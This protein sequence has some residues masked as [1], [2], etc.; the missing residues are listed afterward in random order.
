M[1]IPKYVP[2]FSSFLTLVF[3]SC[4]EN[5]ATTQLPDKLVDLH[6]VR[7]ES[8]EVAQDKLT[9]MHHGVDFAE[10]ESVIGT[11]RDGENEATVYLTIFDGREDH[12]RGEWGWPGSLF[13]P[14][15][16]KQCLD[17]RTANAVRCCLS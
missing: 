11:Y 13:F 6:L 16:Q 12:S 9:K 2:L 8:N 1:H 3:I 7:L 17:F 10:Y 14:G 15:W 5:T 4:G